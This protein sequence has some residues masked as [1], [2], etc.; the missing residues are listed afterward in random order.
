MAGLAQTEL[1][2]KHCDISTNI[3]G[4]VALLNEF[5]SLTLEHLT[6]NNEV[7]GSVPALIKIF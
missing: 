6:I 3:Y 4:E 2:Y 1:H 5:I 7:P